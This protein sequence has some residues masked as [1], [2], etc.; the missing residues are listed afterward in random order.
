MTHSTRPAS[1]SWL[2]D[3]SRGFMSMV[4]SSVSWLRAPIPWHVKVARP[5]IDTALSGSV[6][7]GNLVYRISPKCDRPAVCHHAPAQVPILVGS[8]TSSASPISPCSSSRMSTAPTTSRRSKHSSCAQAP[9]KSP[10]AT[11]M[12]PVACA[13]VNS[14]CASSTPCPS[15]STRNTKRQRPGQ[16][17]HPIPDF[18][19]ILCLD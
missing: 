8:S 12:R 18:P 11:K 4:A 1:T 14:N 9:P 3:S 2:A 15:N 5:D 17:P 16:A 7:I 6:L 10:L 19:A 13:S